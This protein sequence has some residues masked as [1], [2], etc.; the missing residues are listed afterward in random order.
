MN[1]REPGADRLTQVRCKLIGFQH[2]TAHVLLHDDFARDPAGPDRGGNR[3]A[4][5]Q[6]NHEPNEPGDQAVARIQVP[7]QRSTHG[8]MMP[9]GSRE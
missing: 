8:F 6:P 4:R 1:G 5:G 3:K 7:K 2:Q 9:A